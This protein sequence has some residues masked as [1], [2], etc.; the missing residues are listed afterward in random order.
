MISWLAHFFGRGA[1]ASD[2]PL[3]RV[4]TD[5]G[6]REAQNAG[7]DIAFQRGRE[8]FDAARYPEAISRF[9]QSVEHKH[10][11]AEAHYYLGLS[12]HRQ[13]RYEQA[14]DAFFLALCF[15]PQMGSA[16]LALARTEHAKGETVDA[17]QSIE[18]AIQTGER[19]ADV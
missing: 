18:R 5:V 14:C 16:H 6:G 10:D 13:G 11:F 2:S 1:K 19:G 12:Q 9:E 4:E 7:A 15:A 3:S 17:L 8:F